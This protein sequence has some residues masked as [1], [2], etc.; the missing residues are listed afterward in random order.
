MQ[1]AREHAVP[2]RQHHLDDTRH[3]RSGLR[4]TDVGLHRAQQQRPVLRPVLAVGGKQRLRLDRVTQRRPRTVRL[5]RIHVH[6]RQPGTRQRLPDHPLLRRT[7]RRRQTIRRTILVHRPTPHHRQHP[8]PKATRIRQ[9]LQHQD[10]DAFG[11][12]D[13]VRG[14][15]ERLAAPVLRRARPGGRT[16]RRSAVS[17]SPSHRQ[18][19]PASIRPGAATAPPDAGRR[20]TTST[21]CPP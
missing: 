14:I 8:M 13:A 15:G 11:P 18:R 2:H 20:A 16:R 4:V 9:T 1:G 12:A 17:T 21:R 10:S 6:R 3:A 19:V 7:I 5:H